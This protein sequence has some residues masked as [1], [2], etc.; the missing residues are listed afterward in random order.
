MKR[1][2]IIGLFL[3]AFVLM[4]CSSCAGADLGVYMAADYVGENVR[5]IEDQAIPLAHNSVPE[6]PNEQ[7]V[8][9]WQTAYEALLMNYAIQG[10]SMFFL[11]FDFD[12]NGTPEI[13]IVGGDAGHGWDE[14]IDV[15]Y[16]YRD[17]EALSLE[18]GQD[19]EFAPALLAA[20]S[21][22]FEAP[23]NAGGLITYHAGATVGVF[24]TSVY[25]NRITLDG[26]RLIVDARGVRYV[27]I[28]AL[29]ELYDDHGRGDP[30]VSTSSLKEHTY[31]FINDNTVSEDEFYRLFEAGHATE[32]GMV[33]SR[34]TNVNIL[35]V[36]FG[37]P[38]NQIQEEWIEAYYNYLFVSEHNHVPGYSITLVDLNLDNIPEL[39]F[40]GQSSGSI[41][42]MGGLTFREGEAIYFE[43]PNPIS[44]FVGITPDEHG[45]TIWHTYYYPQSASRWPSTDH[46]IRHYDFSDLTEIIELDGLSI[47]FRDLDLEGLT[48]NGEQITV[49]RHYSD[50]EIEEITLSAQEHE[51][52]VRWWRYVRGDTEEG[53]GSL[54]HFAQWEAELDIMPRASIDVNNW[55][56]TDFRQIMLRWYE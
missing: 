50:G 16:T 17:G 13:I 26:D 1:N 8:M 31:F 33:R 47:H 3:T 22:Y 27:D 32:H 2:A 36:I 56:E 30:A 28:N 23:D 15:A 45:R 19:V 53:E 24:G 21:G 29:D 10:E 4:G 43:F 42:T 38:T 5:V 34:I 37:T 11:L 51:S 48:N 40:F 39:L 46:Y 7:I 44:E 9:T 55:I 14:L 18:Y 52:Y 25:Y 6:S 12:K 20:R 49:L 35:E 54:P 41:N